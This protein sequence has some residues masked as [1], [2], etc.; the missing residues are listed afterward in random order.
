VQNP[1]DAFGGDF[2]QDVCASQT[3]RS[4]RFCYHAYR[5]RRLHLWYAPPV[6]Y[7][8]LAICCLMLTC[9]RHSHPLRQFPRAMENFLGQHRPI[10]DAKCPRRENVWHVCV[11]GDA[12]RWARVDC[13][14]ILECCYSSRDGLCPTW[15]SDF[16]YH[17]SRRG[18]W[19]I[20][21]GYQI[22]SLPFSP[23][24]LFWGISCVGLMVSGAG[25][26]AGADGS[27]QPTPLELRVAKGQ[28]KLFAQYFSKH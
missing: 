25:T 12:W 20:S 8:H 19:R 26:F 11:D 7:Y 16:R 15:I 14:S 13:F 24:N 6:L 3:Q 17:E 23:A 22:P 9:D 28:G 4:H 1:R 18:S 27:R 5:I 10:V 2:G 21:L